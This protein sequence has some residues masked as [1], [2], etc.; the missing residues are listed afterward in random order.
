MAINIHRVFTHL[1]IPSDERGTRVLVALDLEKT[2]DSVAWIYMEEVLK[3]YA[4][5]PVFCTWVKLSYHQPMDQIKLGGELSSPFPIERGTRQGCP[6]S[7]GLF[8]LMVEHIGSAIRSSGVVRGVRVRSLEEKLALYAD[9]INL[10]LRDPGPSL[11]AALD[12][13]SHFASISGLK[14]NWDKP[15]ILPVDPGAVQ[16]AYPPPPLKWTEKIKY[17]GVYISPKVQDFCT[18]NLFPRLQV[19]KT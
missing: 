7:P 11:Q 3:V 2:F 12:L 13:I 6:L 1:Q 18:P 10:F 19:F 17:F 15:L 14:V 8:S 16:V 4:F 9:D 5:G